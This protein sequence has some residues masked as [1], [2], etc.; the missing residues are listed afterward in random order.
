MKKLINKVKLWAIR[1]DFYNKVNLYGEGLTW[2]TAAML[3]TML[4]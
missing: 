2:F 4:K 1:N 3:H